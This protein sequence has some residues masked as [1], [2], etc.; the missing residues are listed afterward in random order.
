MVET[1]RGEEAA[2]CRLTVMDLA[3]E[4]QGGTVGP[5]SFGEIVERGLIRD[6]D[7]FSSRQND[8]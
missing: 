2:N 1:V 4:E 6:S 3:P 5:G 7:V 8:R